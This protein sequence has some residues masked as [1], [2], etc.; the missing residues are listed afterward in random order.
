MTH[1]EIT[2]G[3]LS[4]QKVNIDKFEYLTDFKVTRKC[5]GKMEGLWALNTAVTV[6]PRCR[7]LSQVPDFICA[8]CYASQF[9]GYRT[10]S[11]VRFENNY[12]AI[13][14]AIF[15]YVPDLEDAMWHIKDPVV[16]VEEFGDIG[17]LTQAINYLLIIIANPR[18][19][20][21]WWTKHPALIQQALVTLGL[22][23]APSNLSLVGSSHRMNVIEE[24]YRQYPFLHHIFTVYRLSHTREHDVPINCGSASCHKCLRCYRRDGDFYI[25]EILKSDQRRRG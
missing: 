14:K 7:R 18:V 12:R 25:N 16:R 3:N 2:I 17:T 9:L 24:R 23:D 4:V 6:N 15:S 5:S 11:R 21:G 13:N 10:S 8:K 22:T 20:F 1:Q 19:T